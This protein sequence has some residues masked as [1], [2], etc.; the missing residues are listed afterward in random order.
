MP[1]II[2]TFFLVTGVVYIIIFIIMV[3]LLHKDHKECQKKCNDIMEE[4]DNTLEFFKE[5]DEELKRLKEIKYHKDSK[6]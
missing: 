4:L 2:D 5:K 6:T 3:P 1:Q